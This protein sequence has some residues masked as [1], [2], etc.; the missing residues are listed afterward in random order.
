MKRNV[1]ST[2]IYLVSCAV[3]VFIISCGKSDETFTVE[4]K[5]GVRHVHNNAP[6][7]G[8][9]TKVAL[10]FVQKIGDLET[11][12]ENYQLYLHRDVGI[13]AEGNIYVLDSGNYRI[14]KYDRDGKYISTIG[15]EGQGPGEFISPNCMCVD[16][17]GTVYVVDFGNRRLQ[18]FA[19]DGSFVNSVRSR[20]FFLEFRRL[21]SGRFIVGYSPAVQRTHTTSELPALYILSPELA[22]IK[23]FGRLEDK[24]DYM[25]NNKFNELSFDIDND[26]NV[27]VVFHCQNRIVKYNHDGTAL[28]TADRQF[29]YDISVEPIEEVSSSGETYIRWRLTEILKNMAVDGKGR[30][31]INTI[32]VEDRTIKGDDIFGELMEQRELH[33]FSPDG[34]WLGRM[35]IPVFYSGIRIFGDRLFLLDGGVE[36]C[37]YEYKIVEK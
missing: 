33:I 10:E 17:D 1:I 14:Q 4:I 9:T 13:D 15:R 11:E 23:G 7:W 32:I 22:E 31:W 34:V 2:V 3:F 19:P 6:L 26:D 36:M 20:R 21:K 18:I 25:F 27:Y 16:D 37:V 5:D 28:F 8:D 24:K 35:H 29:S 12:D 30:I